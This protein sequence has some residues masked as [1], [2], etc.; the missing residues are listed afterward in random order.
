MLHASPSNCL[1]M[2]CVHTLPSEIWVNVTQLHTGTRS[3]I[4][5]TLAAWSSQIWIGFQPAAT[6]LTAPSL[7]SVNFTEMSKV[8]KKTLTFS[9]DGCTAI[10]GTTVKLFQWALR[11]LDWH[12]QIA[13]WSHQEVEQLKSASLKIVCMPWCRMGEPA[14]KQAQVWNT[15]YQ[16]RQRPRSQSSA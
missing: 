2:A 6:Q 3:D 11:I 15:L 12:S 7:Q 9:D 16:D 10:P 5:P 8:N 4:V 14:G 1:T 13:N